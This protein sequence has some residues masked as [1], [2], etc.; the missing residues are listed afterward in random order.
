MK[1]KKLLESVNFTSYM[2][3]PDVWSFLDE[4]HDVA[5]AVYTFILRHQ[6]LAI[7]NIVVISLNLFFIWTF[8]KRKS[9]KL[10]ATSPRSDRSSRSTYNPFLKRLQARA[11]KNNTIFT[12]K[13]NS[14][15]SSNQ[16]DCAK[17]STNVP[18]VSPT[19]GGNVAKTSFH[20]AGRCSCSP[21]LE[22]SS[23]EVEETL[24]EIT[25]G[26]DTSPLSSHFVAER[27]SA[28]NCRQ[29]HLFANATGAPV[30]SFAKEQPSFPKNVMKPD[31]LNAYR[32]SI[33]NTLNLRAKRLAAGSKV[34]INTEGTQG[35]RESKKNST[36]SR[37]PRR[38]TRQHVY[39]VT[40]SGDSE[41]SPAK[42]VSKRSCVKRRAAVPP[43]RMPK[44]SPLKPELKRAKVWEKEITSD[45]DDNKNLANIPQS[46]RHSESSEQGGNRSET[47]VVCKRDS[48]IW[49]SPE[50]KPSDENFFSRQNK[51]KSEDPR[52]AELAAEIRRQEEMNKSIEREAESLI[53]S[54]S[55]SHKY[56]NQWAK[57]SGVKPTSR[58]KSRGRGKRR[59]AYSRSS[60]KKSCNSPRQLIKKQPDC[61]RPTNH[62][63]PILP[64]RPGAPSY[65]LQELS[66]KVSSSQSQTFLRSEKDGKPLPPFDFKC[67]E[68]V[69][70]TSSLDLAC[71][72]TPVDNTLDSNSNEPTHTLCDIGLSHRN[73]SNAYTKLMADKGDSRAIV[74]ISE[75]IASQEKKS[76][77]S[78]PVMGVPCEQINVLGSGILEGSGESM[79]SPASASGM[80]EGDCPRKRF[81]PSKHFSQRMSSPRNYRNS[82]FKPLPTGKKSPQVVL[83]TGE[84]ES[85]SILR[86]TS[87][88]E[89]SFRQII[90]RKEVNSAVHNLLFDTEQSSSSMSPTT[91]NKVNA[92]LRLRKLISK[93][94][95]PSFLPKQFPNRC[96][97]T[98]SSGSTVK[99]P[100]EESKKGNKRTNIYNPDYYLGKKRPAKK[101]FMAANSLLNSP[102]R[103]KKT[104]IVWNNPVSL[105][106]YSPKPVTPSPVRRMQACKERMA[107]S[108]AIQKSNPT[109]QTSKVGNEK[110]DN[111]F[112]VYK[113]KTQPRVSDWPRHGLGNRSSIKTQFSS[114][115]FS[116][117]SASSK[118]SLKTPSYAMAD[119]EAKIIDKTTGIKMESPVLR[120]KMIKGEAVKRFGERTKRRPESPRCECTEGTLQFSSVQ[121][122]S[123]KANT[124]DA[125]QIITYSD[126]YWAK[127]IGLKRVKRADSNATLCLAKSPTKND[128]NESAVKVISQEN[129]PVVSEENK[130]APNVPYMI[131]GSTN[132]S[133]SSDPY[134]HSG[135]H[136]VTKLQT[137]DGSV[138]FD[139]VG[140]NKMAPLPEPEP[141]FENE[142]RPFLEMKPA[143]ITSYQT[144]PSTCLQNGEETKYSRNISEHCYSKLSLMSTR[145]TL[146]CSASE[147]ELYSKLEKRTERRSPEVLSLADFGLNGAVH[148]AAQPISNPDSGYEESVSDRSNFLQT[149]ISRV[150]SRS[151]LGT[152]QSG[153]IGQALECCAKKVTQEKVSVSVSFC[154]QDSDLP[155]SASP[156]ANL[157]GSSG[158]SSMH[159]HSAYL[160]STSEKLSKDK[161]GSNTFIIPN[162]R[163]TSHLKYIDSVID[164]SGDFSL[165]Y[166]EHISLPCRKRTLSIDLLKDH[167]LQTEI[168]LKQLSTGTESIL[169]KQSD[170]SRNRMGGECMKRRKCEELLLDCS[171]SSS[172]GQIDYSPEAS[173]SITNLIPS[174]P[175]SPA[176]ESPSSFF[177]A[178]TRRD[179]SS[180]T[181]KDI[182]LL[183]SLDTASK[184]ILVDDNDTTFDRSLLSDM[185]SD[186][187]FSDSLARNINVV[188]SAHD[189]EALQ[190]ASDSDS[191]NETDL[192]HSFPFSSVPGTVT[193]KS[194]QTEC[195]T[196]DSRCQ[197]KFNTHTR[198]TP[199]IL[200][201]ENEIIHFSN[202]QMTDRIP[203][204]SVAFRELLRRF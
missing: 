54:S 160:V 155:T 57:P 13:K 5:I 16:H 98:Q 123:L 187:T 137:C 184:S 158:D 94:N 204:R 181:S 113:N 144:Q 140:S 138:Q 105:R 147:E 36:F 8:G 125:Q 116:P 62:S 71:S 93:E 157:Y 26:F 31:R 149:T 56:A 61:H 111:S 41:S 177:A 55:Q 135:S 143:G 68:S 194:N 171:L 152:L 1:P 78:D 174:A 178:N 186:L 168:K 72:Q 128:L 84:S 30:K 141:Y 118:L 100:L 121:G 146:P 89:N 195:S 18:K 10:H 4:V 45:S 51:F 170:Y 126:S 196:G 134:L 97:S 99:A 47:S 85:E 129:D 200:A 151:K 90:I 114:P 176:L 163:G 110:P 198:H 73:M 60:A 3:H 130:M 191:F 162:P 189:R 27:D 74:G 156:I 34:A 29:R 119:S 199:Q 101:H 43:K 145:D 106:L 139:F 159:E 53:E 33:V 203:V 117:T 79:T 44:S 22:S 83:S 167:N 6:I 69:T 21:T 24:D 49:F 64:G 127:N 40:K 14:Y 48:W 150:D 104:D 42:V 142:S 38:P 182:R 66:P 154:S 202:N 132:N 197:G 92:S 82:E 112:V 185:N 7:I 37:S 153:E 164:S 12:A 59:S 133:S 81:S 188:R 173:S 75:N 122:S 65:A 161:L 120:S 32:R 9:S 172:L 15:R 109:R 87:G 96:M 136:N 17:S 192:A 169:N 76:C 115:G 2:V 131:P 88:Q 86:D 80:Y 19:S 102:S 107:G 35:S 103:W 63:T 179:V 67:S 124:G 91:I 77:P 190:D 25:W 148:Q 95:S 165:N 23:D 108:I 20:L 50:T 58:L 39:S 11:Q 201:N 193:R 28:G 180:S 70:E 46:R 166:E 183:E 175:I 52:V